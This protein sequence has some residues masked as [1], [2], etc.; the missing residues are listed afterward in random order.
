VTP[1]GH[2]GPP[3]PK[4]AKPPSTMVLGTRLPRCNRP[5]GHEGPHQELDAKT[6]APRAEWRS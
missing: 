6:F 2:F 1:C 4:K 3:I 5:A